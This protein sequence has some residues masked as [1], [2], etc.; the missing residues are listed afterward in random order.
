MKS[1]LLILFSSLLFASVFAQKKPDTLTN[2]NVMTLFRAGLYPSIIVTK[3]KT[4]ITKFDVTTEGIIKLKSNGIPDEVINAMI[5]PN[6]VNDEKI[7][8][9]DSVS[10]FKKWKLVSRTKNDKP[11]VLNSKIIMHYF[12]DGTYRSEYTNFKI[13]KKFNS[14]GKFEL[15]KDKKSIKYFYE[16]GKQNMSEIIKLTSKEFETR[17]ILQGDEYISFFIVDE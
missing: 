5:N 10:I 13:N 15:S 11:E 14:A 17:V 16:D 2:E 9:I 4:S 7:S 12:D 6:P 3:I 1:L 8:S